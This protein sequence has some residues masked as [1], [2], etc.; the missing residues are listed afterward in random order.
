MNIIC[1]LICY[2]RTLLVDETATQGEIRKNYK[3]FA[4]LVH[5]DKCL[6][7]DAEKATKILNA[8]QDVLGN[9]IER[10]EYD[11]Q[12]VLPEESANYKPNFI[13]RFPCKKCGCEHLI[14]KVERIPESGR[15]CGK[16]DNYH[17]AN[18]GDVWI[19]RSLWIKK[20]YLCVGNTY[21][22]PEVRPALSIRLVYITGD[23]QFCRKALSSKAGAYS[24]TCF[25]FSNFMQYRKVLNRWEYR[26]HNAIIKVLYREDSIKPPPSNS[27]KPH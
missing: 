26:K 23:R 15:Y 3:R 9:P 13:Q 12:K 16:C 4:L 17:K 1:I 8:A 18:P 21:F 24:L 22:R 6:S 7:N 19:E 27:N 25:Y 10:Q 20:L 5:P 14:I 11:R 2:S